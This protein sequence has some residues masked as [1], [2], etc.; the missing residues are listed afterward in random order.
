MKSLPVALPLEPEIDKEQLYG[1]Y[2]ARVRWR[3]KLQRK[4]SHKALDVPDGDGTN[5]ING[6]SGKH[7]LG[8]GALVLAGLLGWRGLDRLQS[9][10]VSPSVPVP[11]QA[12]EYDVT[13]WVD[14]EEITVTEP[15]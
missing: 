7:L 10:G 5:I 9:Q 14:G 1:E 15:E 8:V 13:F 3:D 4:A 12:Q 11:S 6:I 2:M